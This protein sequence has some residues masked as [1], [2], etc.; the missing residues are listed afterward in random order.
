M[1][2]SRKMD[3]VDNLVCLIVILLD[4]SEDLVMSSSFFCA[5]FTILNLKSLFDCII[6]YNFLA[7]SRNSR[8]Q[9][10]DI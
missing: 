5:W 7:S 6:R 8:K 3:V 1:E 10:Q 2:I 4:I 9:N